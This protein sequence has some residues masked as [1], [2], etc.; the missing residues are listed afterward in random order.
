[1]KFFFQAYFFQ[2][3]LPISDYI[4]DTKT[5]LDQAPRVLN[6][7]IDT[8]AELGHFEIVLTLMIISKMIIQVINILF[9][10]SSEIF[11]NQSLV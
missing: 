1:M 2:S 10:V 3:K 5:V 6:A 8:A 11:G 9:I 4:N 7:M